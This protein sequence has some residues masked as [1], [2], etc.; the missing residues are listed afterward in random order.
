MPAEANGLLLPGEGSV[1]VRMYGQGV[2]DCFLLAFPRADGGERPVYVLIDC[3]VIGGTPGGAERMRAVVADIA[4]AT[5]GRLDLLILTHEHWDHLS[6]FD[7]ASE[8]WDTIEIDALWLAW[9]ES[10]DVDGL[11]GVLKRIVEKQQRSLALVAD[12]VERLGAR[13]RE[14]LALGLMG[15]L[16]DTPP[17]GL[18]FS[19]AK[20]VRA[21]FD[22]AKGRVD[23]GRRALLE[24]GE[25]RPLPGAG[26]DVYVLGPPRDDDRLRHVNPSRRD[27]ETYEQDHGLRAR[28]D[29]LLSLRRMADGPSPLSF[30]AAPLL[31]FDPALSAMD[32][33]DAAASPA[34]SQARDVY[35]RSFPFDRFTRVPL[36]EAEATATEQPGAYPA[37]ASYVAGENHWRRIDFD[38]LSAA[39]AFALQADSLTNNTSLAL[40]FEL[41]AGADGARNVLLFPADAQVGALLSWDEIPGWNVAPGAEPA[42]KGKPPDIGD[43]LQRTTFLK[44]GHHGSHNATLKVKGVERLRQGPPL[45]AFV[46]VSP[47]VAR[48]IK[49]WRHMPLDGMLNALAARSGNRVVL[50]NG[51]VWPQVPASAL[52]EARRNI[53]V[54]TSA[55]VMLP[56]IV[57]SNGEV[58]QGATP[59]WL[60]IRVGM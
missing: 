18:S 24:P 14:S 56:E 26:V 5:G 13:D 38:W 42:Q 32:A 44:V 8:Q 15:F 33:A 30:F 11:P 22:A 4:A 23:A 55:P 21:A 50:A 57:R 25:V 53:G 51:E 31:A 54:E 16:G 37:L 49:G 35:E 10:D 47:A 29:A 59:L 1:V 20:T 60:Q 43:L 9:T 40:A 6:G 34:L 17:P 52:D 39:D 2:G 58:I 3:G 48:Q 28:E 36:P 12:R 27:P 41:P 7:Q 45:T 46:P 19:L